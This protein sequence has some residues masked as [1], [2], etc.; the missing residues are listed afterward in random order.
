MF[1]IA[2][3]QL[4]FHWVALPC[5]RLL[6]SKNC[7]GTSSSIGAGSRSPIQTKTT[8]FSTRVGY[9]RT[10]DPLARGTREFG[11]SPRTATHLPAESNVQP[12]YG[13]VTVPENSHL[14]L[15]R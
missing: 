11:P 7:G 6:L 15:L 3:R 4:H 9:D 8:P 10:R 12:W 5:T 13:H 1:S 2:G 14:P